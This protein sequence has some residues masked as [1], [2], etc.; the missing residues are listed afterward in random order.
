MTEG[1]DEDPST[2][3]GGHCRPLVTALSPQRP[4]RPVSGPPTA[5]P[6]GG[7]HSALAGIR[8]ACGTTPSAG[9]R[10]DVPPRASAVSSARLSAAFRVSGMRT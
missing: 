4:S 10:A 1:S 9:A 3:T 7:P 8:Q 2:D 6:V 5:P